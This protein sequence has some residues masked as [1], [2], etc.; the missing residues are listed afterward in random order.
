MKTYTE[1]L[2]MSHTY[3]ISAIKIMI[4]TE[5]DDMLQSYPI[6][7][8]SDEDDD[9]FNRVCEIIYE[10]YLKYDDYTIE[11]LVATFKYIL[12]EIE[13]EKEQEFTRLSDIPKLDY[14]SLI[15]QYIF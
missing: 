4:A 9:I 8:D 11:N 15:K 2:R 10:L 3:G 12:R 7:I 5:L 13:E 1:L 14:R 6:E